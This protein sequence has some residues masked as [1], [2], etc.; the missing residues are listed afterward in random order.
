MKRQ[1]FVFSVALG[2]ILI[3]LGIILRP[4]II[5]MP[6]ADPIARQGDFRYVRNVRAALILIGFFIVS[7][8]VIAREGGEMPS[9][10]RF[11]IFRLTSFACWK[12]QKARKR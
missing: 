8:A 9:F 2:C 3:L 7:L 11:T 4:S 10:A 12:G 6:E 1:L 5:G